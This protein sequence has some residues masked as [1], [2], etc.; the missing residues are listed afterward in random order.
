ML[1][2][3][4]LYLTNGHDGPKRKWAFDNEEWFSK[5]RTFRH[6]LYATI[7]SKDV[8]AAAEK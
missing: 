5:T 2:R 4:V 3:L 7:A 1:F 6:L 8:Q